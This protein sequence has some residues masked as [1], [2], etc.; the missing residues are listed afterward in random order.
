MQWLSYCSLVSLSLSSRRPAREMM[1]A[2][3]EVVMK[4]GKLMEG[5]RR[6]CHRLR[7]DGESTTL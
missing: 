7:L 1:K 3:G 6:Q 5:A 2:M 4:Y